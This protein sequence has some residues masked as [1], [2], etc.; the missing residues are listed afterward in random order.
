[1]LAGIRESVALVSYEFPGGR[2]D[3]TGLLVYS[4]ATSRVYVTFSPL[5]GKGVFHDAFSVVVKSAGKSKKVSAPIVGV[6]RSSGYVFLRVAHDER[7]E[8][9]PFSKN[10]IAYDDDHLYFLASYPF[11]EQLSGVRDFPEITISSVEIKSTVTGKHGVARRYRPG[12]SWLYGELGAPIL[13]QQGEVIGLATVVSRNNVQEPFIMPVSDIEDAMAGRVADVVSGD[14]RVDATNVVFTINVFTVDIF[15]QIEELHVLY[16]INEQFPYEVQFGSDDQPLP[17]EDVLSRQ[18]LVVY[19]DQGAGQLSL[20]VRFLESDYL[21]IQVSYVRRDGSVHYTTPMMN[22]IS[23]WA[24]IKED[25][26]PEESPVDPGEATKAVWSEVD[27]SLSRQSFHTNGI[28]I[29]HLS[30]SPHTERAS[31]VFG[32]HDT[33]V[34]VLSLNDSNVR[35][36]SL[37]DFRVD[38]EIGFGKRQSSGSLHPCRDGLALYL[39]DSNE[40][41]VLDDPSLEV[42]RKISLPRGTFFLAARES[43]VGLLFDEFYE[44]IHMVDLSHGEVLGQQSYRSIPAYGA[45]KAGTVPFTLRYD[46]STMSSDG[47]HVLVLSG[48]RIHRYDVEPTGLVFSEVSPAIGGFNLLIAQ[49]YVTSLAR[50]GNQSIQGNPLPPQGGHYFFNVDDLSNP[51]FIFPQSHE[52]LGFNPAQ[53]KFYTWSDDQ[54]FVLNANGDIAQKIISEFRFVLGAGFMDVRRDGKVLV[55][56]GWASLCV[57]VDESTVPKVVKTPGA[58]SLVDHVVLDDGHIRI[59][60]LNL[61]TPH[62]MPEIIW[63]TDGTSFYLLDERGVLREVSAT[64]LS[65]INMLALPDVPTS[66]AATIN[67]LLVV[68]ENRV[69]VIDRS[70]LTLIRTIELPR[71]AE[72]ILASAG[73][74][75]GFVVIDRDILLPIDPAGGRTGFPIVARDLAELSGASARN[76]TMTPPLHNWSHAIMTPDGK[77]IFS[78]SWDALNRCSVNGTRLIYEETGPRIGG[79]GIVISPDS[80][81]V[82]ARDWGG[83]EPSPEWAVA[84]GGLASLYLFRVSDLHTPVG[85]I[86]MPAYI[87]SLAIDSANRVFYANADDKLIRFDQKGRMEK[88]WKLESIGNWDQFALSLDGRFGL[89]HNGE[90]LFHIQFKP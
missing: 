71:M 70:D 43:N 78:L 25:S 69:H 46:Q 84:T 87:G 42:V 10:T 62:Q 28:A 35:R 13:N 52:R 7:I 4:D 53:N 57:I 75:Y 27:Y 1:M 89:I 81:Y 74:R 76:D 58:E 67:H 51:A 40:V 38:V 33:H 59:T 60:R 63:N 86:S 19:D 5:A 49:N 2:D 8:P 41:W 22:T 12:S 16:R 88:T 6:C 90:G 34:F 61:R 66:M 82:L 79:N 72:K 32:R 9:L 11:A 73:S 45:Q 18:A 47:R 26:L 24:K 80:K 85:V 50:L 56:R 83:N 15:Q 37:S 29:H 36:V 64:N 14:G 44:F 54:L 30:Y 17:I 55:L 48:E 77:Y 20:P 68:G 23:N 65:V 31:S 21:I 3:S 39:G